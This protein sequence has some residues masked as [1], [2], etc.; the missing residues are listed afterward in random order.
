[1]SKDIRVGISFHENK[2]KRKKALTF[3]RVAPQKID[4]I[5]LFLPKHLLFFYVKPFHEIIF[6]Y[7]Q[8]F[9]KT[10]LSTHLKNVV[11][12]SLQDS[13]CLD[14][15]QKTLSEYNRDRSDLTGLE[16]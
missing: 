6:R 15:R 11:K 5:T 14:F 16:N 8:I 7:E 13:T 1:M 4:F 9:L 2:D 12:T 10:L 3:C